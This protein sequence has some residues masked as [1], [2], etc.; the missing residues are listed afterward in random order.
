MRTRAEPL[1]WAGLALLLV[2]CGGDEPEAAPP[3]ETT[4][5][6]PAWHQR[7]DPPEHQEPR[8]P[9][10]ARV[11]RVEA[12]EGAPPSDYPLARG[13]ALDS[14]ATIAAGQVTLALDLREG[15]QVILEPGARARLADEA[16]AQI[17]LGA[18]SLRA[19]LPPVG[20]SPRPPLR[21]GT[22]AG[23]VEVGG[24]GQVWVTALPTGATWVAQL[25][26]QATVSEDGVTTV[27]LT[28]GQSIVIGA[29]APTDGPSTLVEARI[30]A[31]ALIEQSSPADPASE[32]DARVATMRAALD[33]T[34][35]ERSR[36]QEVASRQR[37]AVMDDSVDEAARRALQSQLIEHSRTL[38]RVRRQ[39]LVAYE[40]ARSTALAAEAAPDPTATIRPRV[41]TALGL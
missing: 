36:G 20:S 2:A 40:R 11:A 25:T 7:P 34:I 33:E 5:A 19:V 31:Q 24:S 28:P 16:P 12:A 41:R 27:A 1:A 17:L 15:A 23:T 3:D 22:P 35:L 37:A 10:A 9:P 18:G 26:G 38:G 21:I 29:E 32:L 39:L 4:Q 30:A 8:E 6:S 13:S 14:T